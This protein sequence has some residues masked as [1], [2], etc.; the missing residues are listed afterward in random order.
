[1]EEGKKI[2][3]FFK[4]KNYLSQLKLNRQARNLV[5]ENRITL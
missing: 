2:V 1:L 4:T 3:F 5:H